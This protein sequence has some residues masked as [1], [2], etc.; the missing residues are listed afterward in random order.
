MSKTIYGLFLLLL[1][2]LFFL[3]SGFSSYYITSSYLKDTTVETPK[4]LEATVEPAP[5]SQ[6]YSESSDLKFHVVQNDIELGV[7]DTFKEAKIIGENLENTKIYNKNIVVWSTNGIFQCYVDDEKNYL[8]ENYIDAYNY[9]ST[10]ENS[11]IYDIRSYLSLYDNSYEN[12]ITPKKLSS[13]P[14]TLSSP[15]FIKGSEISNLTSLINSAGGVAVKSVLHAEISKDITPYSATGNYITY[16]DPN[17]GLVGDITTQDGYGTFDKPLYDL[18]LKYLPTKALNLTKVP[19][20][21]V[22]K[23]IS[24]GSPVLVVTND[25]FKDLTTN[26]IVIWHTA[27]DN[28]ISAPMNYISLLLIGFDDTYVY[29]NNPITGQESYPLL[30]DDFVKSWEQ[31]GSIAITYVK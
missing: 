14:F 13:I 9:A 19:F 5:I 30:K 15:E 31:F 11:S 27:E 25:T 18:L 17:L 2:L 7:Y 28:I 6:T 1:S 8:F 23:F 10:V 20:S 26:E 12:N 21:E 3:I 4:E 22:E 24:N 29:V 16:G